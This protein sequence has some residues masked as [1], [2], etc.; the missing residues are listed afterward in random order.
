MRG[1]YLK[2]PN[3]NYLSSFTTL[4]EQEAQN[5]LIWSPIPIA[6][7]TGI[8]FHSA[9]KLSGALLIYLNIFL[10][11]VT[12]LIS[13][14]YKNN[15]IHYAKHSWL[16]DNSSKNGGCWIV[17]LTIIAF[18]FLCALGYSAAQL[19]T[20]R[21]NHP[22]LQERLEN[23]KVRGQVDQVEFTEKGMR[24]YLKKIDLWQN[25]A[26]KKNNNRL[27]LENNSYYNSYCDKFSANS[28]P[29]PNR[30][31]SS[32]SYAWI[33]NKYSNIY[34][35]NYA[36]QKK[37]SLTYGHKLSRYIYIRNRQNNT[38]LYLI[39]LSNH[40]AEI[41][42]AAGPMPQSYVQMIANNDP[43]DIENFIPADINYL[44][45]TSRYKLN[46][47]KIGD[48]LEV[49]AT[50]LPL[51]LPSYPNGF[52]FARF[53]YFKGLAALGYTTGRYK[54]LQGDYSDALLAQCKNYIN[55]L[56]QT[57]ALRIKNAI[58]L[59]S[60]SIANALLIGE[61]KEIPLDD[62]NAIRIAGD[63]KSVV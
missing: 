52:D 53:A 2:N 42:L 49:P 12:F 44:R 38:N 17:P 43:K 7:G 26:F 33:F 50:L 36:P 14:L 24:V 22:I 57:I 46:N 11:T 8:F 29:E 20:A 61:T 1:I 37:I 51:P 62:F 35:L 48:W 16:Q 5:W 3:K 21:L 41:R 32:P 15:G 4:V 63:R 30:A 45:L 23:I 28:N 18:A 31:A 56:R 13:H 55:Q 47:I 27:K 59:A 6:I 9:W 54:Q 39:N 19:R 58:P 60:A 34:Y 25:H 40:L 10:L